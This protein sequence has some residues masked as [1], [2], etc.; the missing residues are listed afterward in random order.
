MVAQ[1][2]NHSIIDQLLLLLNHPIIRK[3]FLLGVAILIA[4]IVQRRAPSI[5]RRLAAASRVAI[6]HPNDRSKKIETL[7][8]LLS[9]LIV[10]CAFG[11]IILSGLVLFVPSS[12]IFWLIGLLAAGLGGGTHKMISDY[13]AGLSYFV[14]DPFD[15]G[16][17]IE[18]YV[19]HQVTGVVEEVSIRN[20]YLR[21]A[22]GELYV[23]P[24][25]E[26]RSIRNYSRGLFSTAS[27]TLSVQSADLAPALRLLHSLGTEAVDLLPSLLEP[28]QLINENGKL[29]QTIELKLI[30]KAQYGHATELRPQLLA[31]LQERFTA[32]GIALTQGN[33]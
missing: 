28:W 25:G 29:G 22:T 27:V 13:V 16:E 24:N 5:A 6:R 31:L 26:I 17:K 9:S 19:P 4:L 14:E 18:V 33:G 20:S 8:R 32:A 11:M 23:I 12:N 3:L 10:V 2:F 15:V 30:A 7:R 21:L 1:L